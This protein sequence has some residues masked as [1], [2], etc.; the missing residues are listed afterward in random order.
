M[1]TSSTIVENFTITE[2][3]ELAS[4]PSPISSDCVATGFIGSPFLSRSLYSTR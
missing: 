2:K 1:M 4:K 3:V